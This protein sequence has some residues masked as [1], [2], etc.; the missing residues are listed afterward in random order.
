MNEVIAI[1]VTYNRKVLLQECLDSL[2]AQTYPLKKILVINNCSTDGTEKLFAQGGKYDDSVV[3]LVNTGKNL[4]GAGGFQ[5]GIETAD[6]MECDWVWIMDD[7]SIPSPDAL[8]KL[9]ESAEI[10]NREGVRE[11][12]F[13]A[14]AVFGPDDEPM[15]VP[16]LDAAVS[17]NGYSDWYRY[18]EYGIVPVTEATFVSILVPHSA[19]RKAGYPMGDYFIWGD[20]TEYTRRLC[21]K[22]GKAYFCGSSRVLHKRF[23]VRKISIFNENNADRIAMYKYY[24][25]NAL[26]NSEKYESRIRLFMRI[27]GYFGMSFVCLFKSG[28]KHRFKKFVTIQKG[29]FAYLFKSSKLK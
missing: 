2:L 12:G 27:A 13:L 23:N 19:I 24:F 6:S 15:N 25:R 11:V 3:E 20:D 7:D 14:S 9:L 16:R 28:Q 26:L 8:K 17:E 21:R 22:V 5:R 1:V 4:G 18:L 29:I 10:L